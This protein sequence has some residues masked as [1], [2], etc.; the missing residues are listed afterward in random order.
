MKRDAQKAEE[1]FIESLKAALTSKAVEDEEC[2]GWSL[3]ELLNA[4]LSGEIAEQV[5]VLEKYFE[6]EFLDLRRTAADFRAVGDFYFPFVT[7]QDLKGALLAVFKAIRREQVLSHK[8]TGDFD[9]YERGAVYLLLFKS[10]LD[11]VRMGGKGNP[12]NSKF[13][14]LYDDEKPT[15]GLARV[16]FWTLSF[17]VA[18]GYDQASGPWDSTLITRGFRKVYDMVNLRCTLLV[19]AEKATIKDPV[20]EYFERGGLLGVGGFGRVY[21]GTPKQKA[22]ETFP[23]V[24]TAVNCLWLSL[25]LCIS[26]RPTAGL[27]VAAV[28]VVDTP[29]RH[30]ITAFRDGKVLFVP[31]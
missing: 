2:G 4:L 29:P 1:E 11:I 5:T 13:H 3:Q 14:K 15:D 23:N 16:F 22:L 18:T 6:G 27:L 24:S 21:A 17:V 20:D 26:L 30:R 28:P 7:H 25:R 19:E 9:S 10:F 12:Y 31:R 8:Q